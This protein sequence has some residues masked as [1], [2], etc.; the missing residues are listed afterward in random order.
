[1]AGRPSPCLV[2]FDPLV[3]VASLAT[4]GNPFVVDRPSPYLAAFV[5]TVVGSPFAMEGSRPFVAAE[6]ILTL[7]AVGGSRP[8]V[9][10]AVDILPLVVVGGSLPL[11]V[12]AEGSLPLVAIAVGIL[13]LAA[14]GGNRPFII[15]VAFVAASLVVAFASVV[16]WVLGSTVGLAD[17]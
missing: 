2:A 8:L 14:V 16:A 5:A 1:M 11:V 15:K 3:I 7:V 9:A 12:V 6:G 17:H 10:I 4:V 13:P